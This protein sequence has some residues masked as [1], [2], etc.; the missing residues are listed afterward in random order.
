MSS[1]FIKTSRTLYDSLDLLMDVGGFYSAVF[2]IFSVLMS[3][4]RY[5][6]LNHFL[7]ENLY[8]RQSKLPDD[9]DQTLL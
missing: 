6:E 2:T 7:V 9:K 4:F 1:N 5:H 3:L 8:K